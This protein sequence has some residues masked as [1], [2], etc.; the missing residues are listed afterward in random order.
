MGI[1]ISDGAHLA[2]CHTPMTQPLLQA[3]D[4]RGAARLTTDAVSGLASLVEAMHARIANL[5]RPRS[6]HQAASQDERTRGLTGLVYETVRGVTHLVRGG[7]FFAFPCSANVDLDALTERA[8]S[9]YLLVRELVGAD[10]SEPS[11]LR[12]ED[13]FS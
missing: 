4:L 3:A 8:R 7:C 10:F 1:H 13:A 12:Q 9:N 11:I 2:P 6:I 5:P